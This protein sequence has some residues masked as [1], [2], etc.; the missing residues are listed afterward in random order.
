[1]IDAQEYYR[2]WKRPIFEPDSVI[3][4]E[5]DEPAE[6]SEDQLL[7]CYYRVPALSLVT[8]RWGMVDVQQI[9]DINFHS[10]TFAKLVLLQEKKEIIAALVRSWEKG[11]EGFDDLI[12]GKGK[13]L[14]FLLHGPPGVGKTFTAG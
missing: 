8:K 5:S 9:E 12:K 10:D 11:A 3:D 7:V 2:T 14:I 1:M 4:T 6:L 13:G